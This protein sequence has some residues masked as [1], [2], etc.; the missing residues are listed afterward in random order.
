MQAAAVFRKEMRQFFSYQCQ[1]HYLTFFFN[2]ESQTKK[3]IQFSLIYLRQSIS[4]LPFR[5]SCRYLHEP[6]D[7]LIFPILMCVMEPRREHCYYHGD[8]LNTNTTSAVQWIIPRL[9]W[10][11][12][13]C[14]YVMYLIFYQ[15]ELKENSCS[16]FLSE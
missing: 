10:P 3:K 7:V 14:R 11:M 16:N 12:F 5:P 1:K 4:D 13:E 6:S 9:E 15:R 8:H 2:T